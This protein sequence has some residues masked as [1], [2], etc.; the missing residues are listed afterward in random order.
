MKYMNNLLSGLLK[1]W[2]RVSCR[3]PPP[4]LIQPCGGL[5]S[6][7]D[8]VQAGKF[9]IWWILDFLLTFGLLASDSSRNRRFS[10][11][12]KAFWALARSKAFPAF[13]RTLLT[14]REVG[15]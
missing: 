11:S 6:L 5:L 1:I 10:A 8:V 7:S 15:D 3:G 12:K 2:S 13:K 4:P 9:T 14:L